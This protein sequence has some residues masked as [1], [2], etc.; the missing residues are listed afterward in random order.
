M[1]LRVYKDAGNGTAIATGTMQCNQTGQT[2]QRAYQAQTQR[3]LPIAL[4]RARYPVLPPSGG[5]VVSAPGGSEAINVVENSFGDLG[6]ARKEFM[7]EAGTIR[8]YQVGF[9]N[10]SGAAVTAFLGDGNTIAYEATGGVPLPGT[11]TISGTWGANSLAIF[12]LVTSLT[13]VKIN[14]VQFNFDA[15]SFLTSG[16]AL[17][18]YKT[19]PDNIESTDSYNLATWIQ[20]SDFQSLVIVNP[21][22]LRIVF[23]ASYALALTIPNGRTVTATLY[24]VSVAD[25]HNF[26]KTGVK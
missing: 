15:S 10:G 2:I 19:R 21:E 8:T 5:Q 12:R 9:T 3:V 6:L 26:R 4:A 23:D 1:Y 13:P 22:E 7:G 18:G 20:P 14:K 11:V 16:G 24:Y 17:T 25:V